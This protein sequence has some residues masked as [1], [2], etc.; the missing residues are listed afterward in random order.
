M[1]SRRFNILVILFV[2][3]LLAGSLAV[4]ATKETKLGLDLAG[5]TQLV[6]E[7]EPTPQVPNPSG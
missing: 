7:A 6:Y 1:G 2:A 4:I 5:G 3:G